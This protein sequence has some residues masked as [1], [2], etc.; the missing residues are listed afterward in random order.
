MANV[1]YIASAGTGKTY[2]LV[3]EVIEKVKNGYPIDRMLIITFT[4]KA[5][6]QLKNRILNELKRQLKESDKKEEKIKIHRQIFLIDR[7]YIGT[8]HSVFLRFLKEYPEISNIDSSYQ[9]VE[10]TDSF[11]DVLFEKWID[12]DFHRDSDIWKEIVENIE[13][14]DLKKA[15]RTLY[16]NRTKLRYIECKPNKEQIEVL[17]KKLENN[18]NKLFKYYGKLLYQVKEKH[19]NLFRNSPFEIEQKLKEKKFVDLPYEESNSFIFK[20]RI[21]GNRDSR[22]FFIEKV[23]PLLNDERFKEI[24]KEIA[25]LIKQLK[26]YTLDYNARIVLKKFYDFLSFT[27]NY[28]SQESVL[29]FND[30]LE[31][32][33]ELV[34]NRYALES[35]KG[36][37]DFIF[38]DELQDSDEIQLSILEKI[39]KDNL[40]TFGDPKQ[41]I[42]EWREADLEGYFDFLKRN[43]FKHKILDKNYR[44]S[45]VLIDFFNK[46]FTGDSYLNHI[47]KNFR[48]PV[49]SGIPEQF[50][51]KNSYVKLIEL[52]IEKE[53]KNSNKENI[54]KEVLFTVKLIEE[55]VKEGYEFSQIMILFRK[56]RHIKEFYR[57]LQEFNIPVKASLDERFIDK[58]EIRTVLEILKFIEFPQNK[59]YLLNVL[60][61][62]F[63]SFS[64]EEI[65]RNRDNLSS[66][67][68]DDYGLKVIRELTEEKLDIPID[69]IINRIFDETLILETF[70]LY[71]DGKFKLNNLNKLK[72]L[73]KRLSLQGYNLRDFILYLE[74]ESENFEF[75]EENAVELIT[76]HRSKGLEREVV[77][78]PL[79]SFEP[80][81]ID[82]QKVSIFEGRPIISM[83][84]IKSIELSKEEIYKELKKRAENESERLFYV[85]ATRAKEKLIFIKSTPSSV[86][87]RNPYPYCRVIDRLR[88]SGLILVEQVEFKDL[89]IKP[90]SLKKES[91]KCTDLEKELKKAE[92]FEKFIQKVFEEALNSPKFT[93]V[94]KLMAQEDEKFS[95]TDRINSDFFIYVGILIH[96]I[97][98]DLDFSNVK[99]ETI[100][101]ILNRKKEIVPQ[102]F[103]ES[104]LLE[105]KELM[106]RFI[107]SQIY[108][109][110]KKAQILFKEM[111][112]V[113]KEKDRFIEGRVDV[114]YR[115]N[116]EIVVMDYKTNRYENEEE[117]ERIAESYKKQKE[118]YIKAIKRI[119]PEEKIKFKLGLLWKGEVLELF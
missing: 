58:E 84:K 104:V 100:D 82:I 31:K 24:E 116:G 57:K 56:N 99:E 42:Y 90:V 5:S 2:S 113:F 30:I 15:I 86:S 112:F 110:L 48:K 29:D 72:A 27:Q 51:D 63:V 52:K 106:I 73:S 13:L 47:D 102:A 70:S 36:K 88:D 115:L 85:A 43:K 108:R 89:D 60:K 35:I 14:K 25:S 3:K 105:A 92:E 91:E 28:K 77:I 109:E 87:P 11:F 94:S 114:I 41:C 23:K 38:V 10:N 74:T 81:K 33:L 26:L 8:F 78:I 20:T 18:I 76:M 55:L 71:P 97:L 4:E 96:S 95:H 68:L 79:I 67:I 93:S 119:F 34:K 39:S 45:P 17:A 61:S 19:K 62:P 37:F 22:T 40:Y 69:E 21:V 1:N 65:Y 103:R 66:E 6:S 59:L 101:E 117:K 49:F 9:I 83:G 118:Y 44:S 46:L 98:E 53:N 80:L 50:K 64:P 7:A 111:P 54:E 32:T 12:E 75:P 107:D 16:Y